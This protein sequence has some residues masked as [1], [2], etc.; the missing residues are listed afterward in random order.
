MSKI[1]AGYKQSEVGVIPEEWEATVI[2]KIVELINGRGFKPHEWA[3]TGLPII[4]IQN[5]NGSDEF[6]YYSGSYDPK[7]V[8]ERG[9]LLFAWSGS[10][11]TS[12]GP[13][14]WYGSKAVLNYHTWKI[15][16]RSDTV[17]MDY[18][19]WA[20]KKLTTTIEDEAHG[21]SALVH[22]QKNEV[23]KMRIPLPPLPE[24]KRISQVLGDV[25]ALIQ[26]LEALIA[27]KRDIKQAAMKEL[28][29]GKRRLPGFSG[30]WETKKLGDV[31]TVTMGQSPSSNSYNTGGVGLPLIQGNADIANRKTI[32]RFYTSTITKH[33]MQGDLILTVRAPV[34]EV[35]VASFDCCL[36]RGVCSVRSE[37]TSF[38]FHLLVS[39]EPD[40]KNLSKGS[41]FDSVNSDE[42]RAFMLNIP[43]L[44]EQTAIA[45][46][47]SDMDSELAQLENR[48]S[49][50]HDLKAG[51]MQE[52]LT[53]KIRLGAN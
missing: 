28:L 17:E 24:Q 42:V 51:L 16:Q 19:F 31:A 21:A 36:G 40:W 26:K 48:L 38:L 1:P 12:F 30:P 45:Q 8:V 13:H 6:N 4:R 20:L 35:A 22:T 34:G 33:G 44:P 52:L 18:L 15:S 23:E 9:Q 49:K 25:D 27:K 50:T 14:I 46:V 5:L 39:R 47:L 11:G 7:L 2:S 53:G 32:V 29:T 41:T 37:D 3:K 43:P 10:R